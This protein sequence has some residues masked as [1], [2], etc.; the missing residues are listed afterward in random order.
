[1]RIRTATLDDIDELEKF[2][3]MPWVVVPPGEEYPDGLEAVKM[4]FDRGTI[5]YCVVNDDEVIVGVMGYTPETKMVEVSAT[6][7]EDNNVGQ[8]RT[9]G[10]LFNH[11]KMMHPDDVYYTE[12]YVQH[13][14]MTMILKF[15]NF[16][17]RPHP[18][19]LN[20][21][22]WEMKNGSRS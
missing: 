16:I 6:Q 14:E 15:I 19:N 1:M 4:L 5:I 21:Y 20:R 12:S 22:A 7:A 13:F 17:P 8:I 9:L 10:K 11:I 2:M 18:T 3:R